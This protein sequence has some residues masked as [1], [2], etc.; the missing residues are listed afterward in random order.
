M[1]MK[2][3]NLSDMDLRIINNVINEFCH[4][5]HIA[6][7]QGTLSCNKT[8]LEQMLLTIDSIFN[9]RQRLQEWGCSD[10]NLASRLDQDQIRIAI[11]AL[12]EIFKYLDDGDIDS[13]VGYKPNAINEVKTK[14]K[15]I[16][17]SVV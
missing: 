15:I 5:L 1:N 10:P 3:D 8:F 16:L 17:N 11:K 6:D 2:F 13:R 9:N 12:D 4:G 14:L 7:L